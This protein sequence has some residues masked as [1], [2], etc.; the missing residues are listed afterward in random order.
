MS[1]SAYE[2]SGPHVDSFHSRPGRCEIV[3]TFGVCARI[4]GKMR[5]HY[6]SV[7]YYRTFQNTKIS[8]AESAFDMAA[9]PGLEPK[10][11]KQ[12][13]DPDCCTTVSFARG[14]RLRFFV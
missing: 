5:S 3:P 13:L 12:V 1:K 7:F 10:E 8:E 14:K 9:R 2:N 6:S 11:L 4:M